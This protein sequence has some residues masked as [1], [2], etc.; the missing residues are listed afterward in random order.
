[1]TPRDLH[2][3]IRL[4]DDVIIGEHCVL[5]C[6]KETRL[7]E[8]Q[9]GRWSAG[10]PVVIGDRSLLFN[11]VIIQEGTALGMECVVEDRARIG[12]GCVIGDR[13][14]V[15]HGAYICDR[16]TIGADACVAG[17]VCD[18][19]VRVIVKSCGLGVVRRPRT[20]G[21]RAKVPG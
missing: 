21:C 15:V 11:Q 17:F 10:T 4:G 8:A 7:R 20:L 3:P 6:P 13:T 16:V 18:A 5:G 12:Y 14:R 1:M 2:G 19:T 9:R